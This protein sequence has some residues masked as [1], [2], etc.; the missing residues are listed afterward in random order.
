M[1]LR[2]A[3]MVDLQNMY[4]VGLD[5]TI[6]KTSDGAENWEFV[7][8]QTTRHL[9]DIFFGLDGTGYI[10]GED[11]MILRKPFVPTFSLNFDVKDKSGNPVQN[12]IVTL[13]DFVYPAGTYSFPG[14]L[15]GEY[16]YKISGEGFCDALG[17]INLLADQTENVVLDNCF[18]LTF[19]VTN[20]FDVPIEGADVQLGTSMA[21]TNPSGIA[22]VSHAAGTDIDY[23]ISATKF[24]SQNGK[25][26]ITQNQTHTFKLFT[27]LQPP[28][29][30][31]ATDVSMEGFKANW[32]KAE[33]AQYALLFV[34]NDNFLTYLSGYEGVEV[35]EN[36]MDVIGLSPE[37]N[38]E[39]KLKSVNADGESDFSN[40]IS[41]T[42][43][44]TGLNGVEKI[45]SLHIY[46]NP[47]DN[48]INLKS[49]QL[50]PANIRVL[51]MYG[52]LCIEDILPE[53]AQFKVDISDLHPGFYT[54]QVL[55]DGTF[56][57]AL[58]M[59]N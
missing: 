21:K 33:D 25:I 11:G 39:Y 55:T 36:S 38:Y 13:N 50:K 40:V 24:L 18:S 35:S 41:V 28:V 1:S 52:R 30:T 8:S 5:G 47:A 12:A 16:K 10:L 58:F 34:S 29:A 45:V 43:K 20:I 6:G 32:E 14:L 23:L 44:T 22:I 46:P 15:A 2:D 19:I 31:M 9:Y 51:D 4:V 37:T 3:A 42:T 48:Q 53:S 7:N 57:S 17:T 27:A 54:I 56:S 26:D 49:D 59:K